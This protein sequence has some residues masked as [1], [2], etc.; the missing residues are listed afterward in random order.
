MTLTALQKSLLQL[1]AVLAVLAAAGVLA[2]TTTT[3]DATQAFGIVGVIAG[4]TA[5]AGGI[6]LTATPSNMLPHIVLI[7]AVLGLMIALAIEGVWGQVEVT[8]VFT[9]IIG[10]GALGAGSSIVTTKV[11]AAAHNPA[12]PAAPPVAV[13]EVPPFHPIEE[14]PA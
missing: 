8:G 3:L 10:G 9:F 1:G 11:A 7:A 4:G 5:V 2:V 13:L 6:A 14:P 12:P